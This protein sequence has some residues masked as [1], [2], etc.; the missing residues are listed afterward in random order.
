[1]PVKRYKNP[2]PE[3]FGLG[4]LPYLSP[5]AGGIHSYSLSVLDALRGYESSAPRVQVKLVATDAGLL[6]ALGQVAPN[7]PRIA[8][9]RPTGWRRAVIAGKR[10]AGEGPHREAW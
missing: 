5:G 8:L 9:E 3:P 1:M 7:W 10:I 6:A 2:A 4:V